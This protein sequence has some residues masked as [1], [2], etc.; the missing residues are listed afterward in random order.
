M[1]LVVF[2]K[3]FNNIDKTD[4]ANP[5]KQEN[6]WIQTHK[7]MTVKFQSLIFIFGA[8]SPFQDWFCFWTRFFGHTM[9]IRKLNSFDILFSH[10]LYNLLFLFNI[11][12]LFAYLTIYY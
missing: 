2:R 4:S 8:R 7:T 11:L 5:E 1:A 6:Y 3:S 10:I 9:F 12:G